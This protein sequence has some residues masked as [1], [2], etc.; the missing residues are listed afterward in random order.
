MLGDPAELELLQVCPCGALQRAA[1]RR[2]LLSSSYSRLQGQTGCPH[3]AV[4]QQRSLIPRAEP[5]NVVLRP[6][7]GH[8]AGA[9]GARWY[10]GWRGN[11]HVSGL[12][13]VLPNRRILPSTPEINHIGGSHATPRAWE[14]WEF[15]GLKE[16]F[17]P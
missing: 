3:A 16:D 6:G 15:I 14:M 10:P 2:S 1:S 17:K 13:R 5:L 4:P 7:A 12:G 11:L 8:A 9:A